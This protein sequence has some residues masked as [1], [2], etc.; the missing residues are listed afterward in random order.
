[1]S[2]CGKPI[3]GVTKTSAKKPAVGKQYDFTKGGTD[4]VDQ[5][6]DYITV[7]PKSRRWTISGGLSYILDTARVNSQTIYAL[8]NSKNLSDVETLSFVQDLGFSLAKEHLQ[9]RYENPIGL[10]NNIKAYIKTLLKNISTLLPPHS[11]IS[12]TSSVAPSC[13]SAMSTVTHSCMSAMLSVT[14]PSTS[15]ISSRIT[16]ATSNTSFGI[17]P[18]ELI[19]RSEN[20]LFT[21]TT[22]SLTADTSITTSSTTATPTTLTSLNA[23]QKHGTKR[24]RCKLCHEIDHKS[25][26]MCNLTTRSCEKC[27]KYICLTKHSYLLC[28]NCG[29]SC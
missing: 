20:L 1:M 29:S 2:T 10:Q 21:S 16:I 22:Q 23:S 4:I 25:A 11:A 24:S 8:N 17:V 3:Y 12:S 13:T 5:L 9:R 28:T 19:A 6:T 27:K 18:S 26:K 15:T 7:K 14:S